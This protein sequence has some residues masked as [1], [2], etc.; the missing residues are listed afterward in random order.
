MRY[1]LFQ[2][3]LDPS[4]IHNDH[5]CRLLFVPKYVSSYRHTVCK[6]LR[7]GAS[8]IYGSTCICSAS[9]NSSKSLEPMIVP[10]RKVMCFN[11]ICTLHKRAI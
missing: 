5:V 11:A 10:A 7:G 8:I 4:Q 3:L 9:V 6:P 2:T 1:T